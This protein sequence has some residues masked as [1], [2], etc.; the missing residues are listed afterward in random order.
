MRAHD[1]AALGAFFRRVVW[2][3]ALAAGCDASTPPAVDARVTNDASRCAPTHTV[4]MP[5]DADCPSE[6]TLFPCELPPDLLD[7]SVGKVL[8]LEYCDRR[9]TITSTK[10][11]TYCYLRPDDAGTVFECQIQCIGGRRPEGFHEPTPTE[12]ARGWFARQAALEAASV[13]AFERMADELSAHGAPEAM[14]RGARGAADDERHHAALLASLAGTGPTATIAGPRAV[15]AL[16]EVAVENAVEGCVRECF[17]ALVATWQAARA[18]DP[19]V[20]AAMG[21]VAR[22]ETRHAALSWAVHVWSWGRLGAQDRAAVRSAARDAWRALERSVA[23]PG[24][25]LVAAAGLPDRSQQA[26]LLARLRPLVWEGL[27]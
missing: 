27:G 18:V 7:A 10:G 22:D 21:R 2:A 19:A 24:A 1:E 4:T 14:V 15:R 11:G 6:A 9:C 12:G 5:V 20:A 23:P 16:R 17:G 26:E 8:D 13:Q 25:E 3:A